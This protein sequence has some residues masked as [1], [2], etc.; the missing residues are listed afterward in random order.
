MAANQLGTLQ[1]SQVILQ[2]ALQLCFLYFP[3]LRLFCKGFREL[4]GS[5]DQLGI[6]QTAY[7]RKIGLTSIGNFGDAASAF[8][9]TDVPLTLANFPQL[10]YDFKVE[11]LN[12]AG[13]INLLDQ[14]A[15]S[16]AIT[17]AQGITSRVAALVCNAKFNTTKNGTAPYLNVAS[18]WTRANTVLVLQQMANDRGIPKR[19]PQPLRTINGDVV[20]P[21]SERFMVIN[22]TVN[23]ALL[24]DS[25]IV[26]EYNN[27][28]NAEAIRTGKLPVVSDFE[29]ALY[30]QLPNT[31][32]NLIGFAG[33]ADALAYVA[34]APKT[35]WDVYPDL[36]KTASF[37]RVVDEATGFQVLMI[38]EGTVGT[39]GL[40]SKIIWLDGLDVGNADNLIRLTSGAIAGTS[41]QLVGLKVIGSGYG[42]TDGTGA[43]AAPTV[44]ISGGGGSGATATA[45]INANGAVTGLTITAAG[46]GYT[47]APTV[48]FTPSTSGGNGRVAGPASAVASIAGLY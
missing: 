15:L 12:A 30:A 5:V 44:T 34:R 13:N 25:L 43:Y 33:C 17:L 24:G 35:P 42:Y 23:S 26:S 16:L 32:G 10:R 1:A 29:L 38:I 6:G 45:T 2:R 21:D 28:A 47:S 27:A 3:E 11:E 4:D 31:D 18:G 9:M 37:A 36:P 20:Q 22:S 7:T 41:G 48:T 8:N 46:S 40:S 14:A 19:L 39:L